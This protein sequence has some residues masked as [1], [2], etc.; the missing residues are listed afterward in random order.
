MSRLALGLLR[1]FLLFLLAACWLA[2]PALAQPPAGGAPHKLLFIATSNVPKGKFHE[3]A[4]MAAPYGLAVDS[5]IVPL[6]AGASAL[7][8]QRLKGHEAVL[9]DLPMRPQTLAAMG[10]IVKN[11]EAPYFAWLHESETPLAGGFDEKQLKNVKA[12][13]RV[14]MITNDPKQ[15]KVVITINVK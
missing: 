1:R 11:I 7:E 12:E 3:L 2:C 10:D 15:P 4:Q 6:G 8:P 14:L 13:P 9:L 5:Y